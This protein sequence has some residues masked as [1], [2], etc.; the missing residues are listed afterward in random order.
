MLA[1]EGS[2]RT[3]RHNQWLAGLLAA[4]AGFVNASGF[5]LIG[6][7]TSHVTGNLGRMS[8][9]VAVGDLHAATLALTMVVAFFA[10]AFL[11]SMAIEANL[12]GR[13][14]YVYGSLL[15]A[16]AALLSTF[17]VIARFLPST[18]PRVHDA[19]AALL[20]A[21][22]GLQ[23]SLVTRLSG[24]VVRTTHLTGVVTDLGIESARWFRFI[25]HH[26]GTRSHVKLTMSSEPV[27]RPH[28]PRLFLLLTIVGAFTIG[29]LTGAVLTVHLRHAALWFPIVGLTGF[30]AWA[31][32][33]AR[34][35]VGAT[36]RPTGEV[37]DDAGRRE[38]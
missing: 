33:T 17:F 9:D 16:E 23:N 31:L 35:L 3:N 18:D 21:A 28:A 30:G 37:P 12:F 13:R 19:Q 20:C 10:G 6:T 7:F 34:E 38:G 36:A 11:A 22:M 32:L 4:A 24:A 26:V 27:Q 14:A 29:G 8:G 2:A 15:L 1:T 25:R 5:L